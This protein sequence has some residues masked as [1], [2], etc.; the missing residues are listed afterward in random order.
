MKRPAV[1]LLLLLAL[2]GC[3]R[4]VEAPVPE[5]SV[6]APPK[7]HPYDGNNLLNLVYGASVVARTAEQNLDTTPVH[8]IDGSPLTQWVSP[9]GAPSQTAVFSFPAPA[10]I[11][12]VGVLTPAKEVP[13]EVRFTS[14]LDGSTWRDVATVHCKPTLAAQVA[15]VQP[16]DSRYLRV[17]IV[18]DKLVYSSL[19]TLHAAGV[20]RAPPVVPEIEGCWRINGAPAVFRRYGARVVGRID[21]PNPVLFEGGSDGRVYRMMWKQ[22]AMWGYA[23]LTV[24]PDGKTLSGLRWHE[25]VNPL[26]ASDA[27]L[28]ERVP[29]EM[30]SSRAGA[31][32]LGGGAV[33]GSS[34]APHP[35]RSLATLGM[36]HEAAAIALLRNPGRWALYGVRFDGADRI[37]AAESK[38]ALDLAAHLIRTSPSIRW[39]LVAHEFLMNS[40]ER[41][42]ARS[43]ARVKAVR[44]ALRARGIN[45]NLLEV[46]A[47]G[48]LR[49]SSAVDSTSQRVME[50]VVELRAVR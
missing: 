32:D 4:P 40:P 8:A 34:V 2:S 22:A 43:A 6:F 7:K 9:P 12:Q 24:G 19:T 18:D 36:T 29:C 30:V 49:P 20:L 39:R 3:Q 44:D 42:H 31:R 47:A 41:N 35:P 23:T 33:R 50:S 16:F 15:N 10:R 27:W 26:H 5:G 1:L 38:V 21:T 28:G 17:E 48:D 11:R 46:M 14:S 37:L 25:E 13:R 45:P